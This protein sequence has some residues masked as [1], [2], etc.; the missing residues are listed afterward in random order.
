MVP[1]AGYSMPVQYSGVLEEARHVRSSCGLFDVSHMGQFTIRGR[2]ALASLQTL[3]SNDLKRL[4]IGQAQYNMLCNEQGGVIDDLVVYRRADDFIYVCVNAA[5]RRNDWI[6]MKERSR[7]VSLDDESDET[8]LIALQGPASENLLSE[9]SNPMLVKSMKYYWASEMDVAGKKVFVS[10]TG[11][12]GEDGFEL[13]I[14][15]DDAVEI[16]DTLCELGKRH[17]L[18]PCGLGAR[19]TLRMEM[20]YPLHGHELSEKITPL[21]AG[22]SWVVKLDRMDPFV[23]QAALKAQAKDGPPRILKGFQIED[24]RIA[25][26]GYRIFDPA[27]RIVIGEI[28]SGTFSPHLNCPIALGFVASEHTDAAIFQIQIREDKISARTARPPF[29]MSRVKKSSF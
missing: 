3:V 17:G 6:W 25:R 16:W 9:I 4:A 1:F 23:G 20:G 2:N 15:H 28:T 14:H 11:Y 22:L 12:T 27:G 8:A 24:R 18:I 5:N 26:S 29:V 19:D 13:Y 7:E 21:E 10:R